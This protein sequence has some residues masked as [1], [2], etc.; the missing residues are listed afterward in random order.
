MQP[1]TRPVKL[2]EEEKIDYI[3]Y[4]AKLRKGQRTQA[5]LMLDYSV[6]T[7]FRYTKLC[8]NKAVIKC[9]KCKSL[10][11]SAKL[12]PRKRTKYERRQNYNFSFEYGY[13]CYSCGE[14]FRS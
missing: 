5:Y 12:I 14:E 1:A 6:E 3:F 2:T 7:A 4:H 10:D 11:I 9:P 8:E 13:T